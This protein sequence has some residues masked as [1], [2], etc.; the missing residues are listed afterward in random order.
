MKVDTNLFNSYQE[1]D[2]RKQL[3]Y[4]QNPDGTWSFRGSFDGS[5]IFFNGL[6]VGELYM[7]AAEAHARMGQELKAG[8][9]L[10]ALLKNRF[11]YEAFTPYS[12]N[13]ADEALD[14]VLQERRKELV[15][16][17]LRWADL[18]RLNKEVKY[19]VTLKRLID[20]NVYEL[21]AN[22]ARYAFLI[23]QNVIAESGIQQNPR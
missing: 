23:P 20:D 12:F 9:Y 21:K 8:E 16:R 10:N 2:L 18:K 13:S 3:Y 15:F 6:T 11:L 22:D 4:Q 19:A 14:I 7:I 5:E 1:K 17:G